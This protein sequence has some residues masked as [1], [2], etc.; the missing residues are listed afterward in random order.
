M[1]GSK[2]GGLDAIDLQ[3]HNGVA[4]QRK[5]RTDGARKERLFPSISWTWGKGTFLMTSVNISVRISK[6][7]LPSMCLITKQ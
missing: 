2:F 6:V 5:K 1:S 3:R 7:S 4:E